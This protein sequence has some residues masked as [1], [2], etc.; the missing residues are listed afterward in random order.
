MLETP[1]DWTLYW[2]SI[3]WLLPIIPTTGR[4]MDAIGTELTAAIIGHSRCGVESR[5][6]LD[7]HRARVEPRAVRGD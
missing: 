5:H 6:A 7:P 4:D 3:M 1:T 2:S